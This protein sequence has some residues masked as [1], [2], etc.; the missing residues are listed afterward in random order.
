MNKYQVTFSI[1][2]V[3]DTEG[4]EN[5]AEDV[6]WSQFGDRIADGLR[7]DD[8]GSIVDFISSDEDEETE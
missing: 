5:D 8:F 6:A 4:D 3:V 7:A 1:S 2:L